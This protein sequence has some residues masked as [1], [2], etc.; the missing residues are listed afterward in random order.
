VAPTSAKHM[1]PERRNSIKIL[2]Q[3]AYRNQEATMISAKRSRS[4]G[5]RKNGGPPK[6]EAHATKLP[7]L[8]AASRACSVFLIFPFLT[9][10]NNYL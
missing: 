10:V 6:E 2:S 3:E 8:L 4:D 1:A 9:D 7:Q 5:K